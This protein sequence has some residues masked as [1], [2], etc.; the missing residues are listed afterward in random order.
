MERLVD[1]IDDAVMFWMN[2]LY[3]VIVLLTVIV[4]SPFI[5]VYWAVRGVGYV[6]SKAK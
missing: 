3:A 6:V 2:I 1:M 4:L 5:A